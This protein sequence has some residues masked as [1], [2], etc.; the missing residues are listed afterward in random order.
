MAQVNR[1]LNMDFES[2]TDSN[3][4]TIRAEDIE[5]PVK[6]EEKTIRIGFLV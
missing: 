6:C 3:M 5:P 4:V 2:I 1:L